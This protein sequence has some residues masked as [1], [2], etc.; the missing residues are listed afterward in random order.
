MIDLNEELGHAL[1]RR[2]ETVMVRDDLDD[3]LAGVNVIRFSDPDAKP[4]RRPRLLLVAAASALVAGTAGLVW[5]QNTRSEPTSTTQQPTSPPADQSL[6]AVSPP[7][8]SLSAVGEIAT[9]Q[10]LWPT[11]VP[12]GYEFQFADRNNHPTGDLQWINFGTKGSLTG[13]LSLLVGPD[14]PSSDK[15]KLVEMAG[16]NWTVT[17]SPGR[18]RGTAAIGDRFVDVG[19]PVSE[20]E[21]LTIIDGLTLVAETQLPAAPLTYR[22]IMTDVGE[23]DVNGE[24]ATM[25]VD[26]SNGWY[27]TATRTA[28]VGGGGCAT[29][30]DPTMTIS[31]YHSA[32]FGVA[33][34]TSQLQM[35]TQG[36]AS[37]D[38]ARIDVEFINGVTSSVVP[39]N[40]SDRFPDVLFWT[41]GAIAALEP[42]QDPDAVNEVLVEIRAYSA[43]GTLLATHTSSDDSIG[44]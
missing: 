25:S 8:V 13:Q 5:V 7:A 11:A 1:A 23:F 4:K 12:N 17:T 41:V 28:G 6:P 40:T 43:D 42:G 15:G 16:R 29:Y 34:S 10:W 24:Q 14:D 30:F 33:E 36:M 38:V 32:S 39:Q 22:N 19:G 20:T 31:R 37:T 44:L 2:A 27:C 3:V 18:A 9:D 35:S 26:E 21:L